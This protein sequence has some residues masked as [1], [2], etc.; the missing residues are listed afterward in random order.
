MP[1]SSP[2]PPP[3]SSLSSHPS[4]LDPADPNY[5]PPP[6]NSLAI[7]DITTP[8][9]ADA[10]IIDAYTVQP[11]AVLPFLSSSPSSSSPSSSPLPPPSSSL[12]SSDNSPKKKKNK[13]G[14]KKNKNNNNN[15]PT[16]S[17]KKTIPKYSKDNITERRK[18]VKRLMSRYMTPTKICQ[19]LNQN[20]KNN[21]SKVSYD[22]ILDD[23]HYLEKEAKILFEMDKSEGNYMFSVQSMLED[24]QVY[25]NDL[26]DTRTS[27]I[28]R[29]K[30]G[31]RN[32]D[33]KEI[34]MLTDSLTDILGTIANLKTQGIKIYNLEKARSIVEQGM[35]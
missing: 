25:K 7:H 11:E 24:L 28:T 22:T 35:G 10:V 1:L 26:E 5:I 17:P 13:S 31:D 3:S 19:L 4:S 27:L 8:A 9:A 20:A 14:K 29:V 32:V 33:P 23:V 16:K 2:L 18:I 12:S 30:N 15:N 34:R 21:A 6:V